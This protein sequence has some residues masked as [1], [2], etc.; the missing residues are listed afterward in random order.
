M[1]KLLFLSHKPLHTITSLGYNIQN[2]YRSDFGQGGTIQMSLT[3]R[4]YT[5]KLETIWD[6]YTEVE[7]WK[8]PNQQELFFETR[9]EGAKN[10]VFLISDANYSKE[11][12]E[13]Y[14]LKVKIPE[15]FSYKFNV[16]GSVEH[17]KGFIDSK[18][19]GNVEILTG[20]DTGYVNLS[21]IKSESCKLQSVNGKI[22]IFSSLEAQNAN[23][24]TNNGEIQ[25][26]KLGITNKGYIFSNTGDINIASIYGIGKRQQP[27]EQVEYNEIPTEIHKNAFLSINN[28]K[29]N[30]SLG[31]VHGNL[32]VQSIEGKISINRCDCNQILLESEKGTIYMNL[33]S[34]SENSI[35]KINK[36]NQL[37]LEISPLFN[38]N[39]F[40]VNSNTFWKTQNKNPK[41]PTLFIKG[42]ATEK[43]IKINTKNDIY[44]FLKK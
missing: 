36:E 19:Y 43:N 4:I 18:T 21:K 14:Y 39:I 22:Q 23:I 20:L 27:F 42:E 1:K 24:S 34:I 35:I 32:I 41:V 11:N 44:N 15:Y 29:S 38:G 12:S 3:N 6:D 10:E 13:K 7:T 26:K 33:N 30:I 17:I 2:S 16:M 40:F 25:I 9:N 28:I 5:L 37:H 8:K 31:N